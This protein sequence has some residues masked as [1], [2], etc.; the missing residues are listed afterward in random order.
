MERRKVDEKLNAPSDF[1]AS[2]MEKA[3]QNDL[4]PPSHFTSCPQ[5]TT[6]GATPGPAVGQGSP[7]SW[8]MPTQASALNTGNTNQ[9]LAVAQAKQ[10][11]LELRRI[12]Q[13]LLE[14]RGNGSSQWTPNPCEEVASRIR[15]GDRN[16]PS[17]K[18]WVDAEWKMDTERL[19]AE[20]E[21]LRG[22][23]D[24]LKE[25]TGRQIEELQKRDQS[26][27]RKSD[28]LEQLRVELSQTKTELGHA[29]AELGLG[30][31]E[32][33]RLSTELERLKRKEEEVEA[34]RLAALRTEAEL[35]RQEM[36]EACRLEVLK[37]KEELEDT[38]RKR[39]AELQQLSVSHCAE[40]SSLR[41]T[42]ADLQE[43]LNHATQ[44]ITNLE[45]LLQQACEER[46]KLTEE[47]SQ[48][49]NAYETQSVTLQRLRNYV[50]QLVPE[51]QE[52]EKLSHTVQKLEREKE[53]LQVTAELLT[54]RLNSLNDILAI[55]EK[56]MGDKILSDPLSKAGPKGSR[57]LH[58]WREKVFVLLVQ[59]RSKDIELRREKVKLLTTISTLEEEVKRQTNQASV[60]QHSLQDRIAE[61]DLEKVRKETV[62]LELVQTLDENRRLK[63]LR[64]VAGSAV[65]TMTE[66]V[67][68]FSLVFE[69]KGRV[70]TIQGL[71]MRKE[72]LW[73]V[74]QASKQAGPAA[75]RSSYDSLH[76]ELAQVCEE[77]NNL[78]QELKRTP[79]LIERALSE[80]QEHFD[81]ELRQ[82]RQSLQQ[83]RERAL[84]CEAGQSQAKLELEEAC[85]D[86][87][88]QKENLTQLQA[89]LVDQQ[90]K[91]EKA[92]QEKVSEIETRFMKQMRELESQLNTA[93]RE[94]TKAVVTLRQ[95]ERQ[96]ERERERT[97][98]VQN[99]QNEQIQREMEEL[100]RQIQETDRDRNLLLATVQENGLL[101]L[102]KK[103][104]TT[105]LHKPRSLSE[106]LQGR[107]SARAV[108]SACPAKQVTKDSLRSVLDEVQ[109][110]SALFSMTQIPQVRKTGVE[111]P[112]KPEGLHQNI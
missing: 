77:R 65:K 112:K 69:D 21:K 63:G 52:E 78:V 43:K 17:H 23:V 97:K 74:Q 22:Q 75:E 7:M 62:E 108:A 64:E 28:E 92:L 15:S 87:E 100:Q 109:A 67:Q 14:M 34:G 54:V 51:R 3:T 41:K 53:N 35:H 27:N 73:R 85:R 94:H 89:Q 55:Q 110:L 66:S 58:C 101:E 26:L 31:S 2:S 18:S 81:S 61:L 46:D 79:E 59:L 9:W 5:P 48:V 102:Y 47:L 95:L 83:S 10:E 19:R 76:T 84:L 70:D 39:Q 60:F 50:G 111:K 98:E 103:A 91:S 57:L 42:A 8:V 86:V 37:L 6:S 1:I 56:E 88:E 16:E 72:A 82:L 11:I 45:R 90:K 80:A 36:E 99:L 25:A 107:P 33:Q 68:R 12:N 38:G 13:R 96:A 104:R 24:T 30:I 32:Q 105:S 20:V 106:P 93:R 71:M 44:E 40:V 49:G 29:R 4:I